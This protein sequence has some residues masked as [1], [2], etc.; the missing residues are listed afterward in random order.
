ML[1]RQLG[2]HWT[3]KAEAY[4]IRIEMKILGQLG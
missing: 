3:K 1:Y 2:P 4:Q